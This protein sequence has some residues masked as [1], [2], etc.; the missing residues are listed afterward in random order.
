MNR[1][2]TKLHW[3][4]TLA[5]RLHS[6]SQNLAL[7]H[8]G[9]A[10]RFLSQSWLLWRMVKS[11]RLWDDQHYLFLTTGYL[12]DWA[13]LSLAMPRYP[14]YLRG[15]GVGFRSREEATAW[16]CTALCRRAL[17][18]QRYEQGANGL[19]D[20]TSVHTWLLGLPERTSARFGGWFEG[21]GNDYCIVV[22]HT[23]LHVGA[24]KMLSL[25][26][27]VYRSTPAPLR[28]RAHLSSEQRDT[29]LGFLKE[30]LSTYQ[31]GFQELRNV[32]RATGHRYWFSVGH[33]RP[34]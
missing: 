4:Y 22:H 15:N 24:Q 29:G 30:L 25:W 31:C 26:H 12:Q 2:S 9:N 18:F 21:K 7:A 13:T 14:S 1:S 28:Q 17:Y 11:V 33:P 34:R 16:T 3:A 27:T 5:A 19:G 23:P 10:E 6:P 20:A 8:S 32:I